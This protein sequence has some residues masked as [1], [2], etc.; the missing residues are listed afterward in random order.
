M[1]TEMT[2]TM[3]REREIKISPS[4]FQDSNTPVSMTRTNAYSKHRSNRGSQGT[5]ARS[6]LRTIPGTTTNSVLDNGELTC[7]LQSF[8]GSKNSTVASMKGSEPDLWFYCNSTKTCK[9]VD[10]F[11]L[12]PYTH[13]AVA[14]LK[15]AQHNAIQDACTKMFRDAGF[16]ARQDPQTRDAFMGAAPADRRNMYR[17]TG[18]GGERPNKRPDIAVD[19][20][21]KTN[22]MTPY[23]K[24]MLFADVKT[25][26]FT[27]DYTKDREHVEELIKETKNGSKPMH[28]CVIANKREYHT[29]LKKLDRLYY[30][31]PDD[32]DH[33]PPG[34]FVELLRKNGGILTLGVGPFNE[35]TED[36]TNIIK[37]CAN[38]AANRSITNGTARDKTEAKAFHKSEYKNRIGCTIAKAHANRMLASLSLCSTSKTVA[39]KLHEDARKG[40]NIRSFYKCPE[41]AMDLERDNRNRA[42]Q[43]DFHNGANGAG[44][45][46]H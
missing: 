32:D 21:D 7:A 19:M 27:G 18:I 24:K 40:H 35:V 16:M 45:R 37:I 14:G 38:L 36:V 10:D 30:N 39:K 46:N 3:E 31:R 26:G 42:N 41:A 29:A 22:T 9:P 1:Q 20:P 34:P 6:F 44:P 5:L 33:L 11:G 2:K 13:I 43:S 17:R 23:L 15:T 25:V 4:L 28:K 12:E 8:L